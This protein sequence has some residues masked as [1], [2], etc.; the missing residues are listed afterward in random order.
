LIKEVQHL[1]RQGV[2]KRKVAKVMKI[3]RGTVYKYGFGS[4]ELLAQRSQPAFTKLEPFQEEIISLLNNKIMRKDV[5]RSISQKGYKGGRT[6]FYYYCEQLV[7]MELV[8][9][10]GN[11][12]ID[13]LRDEKTKLK[14]HYVTRNQIFSYIWSG[15]GDIGKDDIDFIKTSFP[16]LRILSDCLYRFRNIF[17]IK[18]KEVLLEFISMYKD[19]NLGSIKN[20]IASIQKDIVPV[21]NAVV[22]EYS[23]GFV[24][25]TNNKLKAIKRVGYGRCKL[26]LLR[27]KVLLPAFFDHEY[28][29][30]RK[31]PI[32]MD[33]WSFESGIYIYRCFLPIY[34]M[35]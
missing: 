28:S 6:Q 7:E 34:S 13:E 11:L 15:K 14:Y 3:S 31:N 35:L 26:P 33:T 12:R 32:F 19:C 9:D 30:M 10:P 24:E 22:E 1:I 18:S 4:P 16:V 27:A 17:E 20:Y 8:A 2:S 5:Y 25:G 21:T 23:N 29:N